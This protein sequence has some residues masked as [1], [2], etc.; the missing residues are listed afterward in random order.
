MNDEKRTSAAYPILLALCSLFAVLA[1]PNESSPAGGSTITPPDWLP[2]GIDIMSILRNMSVNENPSTFCN[3]INISYQYQNNF[4]AR[5]SADPAAIVYKGDYYLFAS[6]GSGY[7]WSPDLV[8]WNFVYSRMGEID[9]FAPALCVVGDTLYLTH[10][11]EG[12][13]YKS[14]NPKSDAWTR[15][16]RPLEWGDPALF[17]DDDGRVYCYYGLSGD[18][19]M[20]IFGVEL[21]PNNNM[22]LLQ[23]PKDLF[24]QHKAARGFEVPG[25]NNDNYNGECWMEGAWMTKHNNR[26]YLQYAAPG[27]GDASYADGYFVSDGPLGPFTF[28]ENNPVTFK[29][30]GFVRGAGHGSTIKDL[31]DAWWKFDTVSISVS[32]MFERRLIMIPANFDTNSNFITN[33]EFSDYPLYAPHG[34]K[35]SFNKPGPGWSLVSLDKGGTAS[36]ELAGHPLSNAFDENLRT[37]WSAAT[38]DA[39]EYLTA[40]LGRLCAI[41]AVQINFADQDITQIMNGRNNTFVYRYLLEFSPDNRRWFS[42]VD[43]SEAVAAA[44]MAQDT[45]HDYFEFNETNGVP[46]VARYLRL[47]N[48]GP[49]PANGKFAVS[50]LRVFG[51]DGSQPP[52]AVTG[53][54]VSRLADERSVNVSWNASPG[55]EGYMIVFGT[56]GKGLW[57]HKQVIGGTSTRINALNYGVNYEFAVYAYGPGGVGSRSGSLIAVATKPA[58]EQPKPPE[59]PETVPDYDVYEAENGTVSGANVSDNPYAS[60]GKI[61]QNMHNKDAYFELKNVDGGSGGDAEVQLYYANGNPVSDV[62]TTTV[63]LNGTSNGPYTLPNTG[64]WSNFGLFKIDLSGFNAGKTNTLRFVGGNGGFNPDFVQVIYDK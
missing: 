64:S 52:G 14:S 7:W 33:M 28:A 26:Y 15:V 39:D 56:Q 53:L 58:P 4:K 60:G 51:R 59:P 42:A 21:D 2:E 30:S 8:K 57:L 18:Q 50:G 63:I 29:N 55:A 31:N 17:T 41:N 12:A 11:N 19:F 23:G 40:D 20:P 32:H 6:H 43:R 47:T 48:K 3:P 62:V 54:N 38:G 25:D 36:S 10:S 1:C 34:G 46:P 5:E 37:W 35:G 24:F 22:A 61:L 45:S 44:N 13:I 16:S 49:V 9:K 27:T